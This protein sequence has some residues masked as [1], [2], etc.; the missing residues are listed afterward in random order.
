[1]RKLTCT[2]L[3]LALILFTFAQSDTTHLYLG[4]TTLKKNFTQTVTIKGK[5]LQQFPFTNLA[6][7]INVWL[8][9]AL[10]NGS[11]I[12]YV[13][14][15]NPLAD[16]NV[17]SVYDIE[18]ITLVQNAAAVYNTA[19]NKQLVLIKTKRSANKAGSLQAV[20][21]GYVV[22]RPDYSLATG[23]T[24]ASEKEIYHQYYL[25]YRKKI[26]SLSFGLSANYLHDVAP[27]S[28]G[29]EYV[30]SKPFQLNRF[31]LNGYA[32]QQLG[33]STLLSLSLN[34]TPQRTAAEL[35]IGPGAAGTPGNYEL[36]FGQKNNVLNGSVGLRSNLGK[37]WFNHFMATY[38]SYNL[39][40][41][42]S[43]SSLVSNEVQNNH[44][45]SSFKAKSWW[46]Q[47]RF[48]YI[49]KTG[50]WQFEPSVN[51]VYRH[52][53]DRFVAQ[54]VSI[55]NNNTINLAGY[56]A[57]QKGYLVYAVPSF[58]IEYKD[59]LSLQTG[60]L[61]SLKK[62]PDQFKIFTPYVTAT[63]DVVG[64]IKPGAKWSLRTFASYAIANEFGETYYA[65]NDLLYYNSFKN[66]EPRF[67]ASNFDGI[68]QL[69]LGASAQLFNERLQVSYNRYQSVFQE[70]LHLALP[71]GNPPIYNIVPAEARSVIDRVGINMQLINGADIKWTTG[72]NG[73]TRNTKLKLSANQPVSAAPEPKEW[74]GG[75]VNRLQ[76][77]RFNLQL[78]LAYLT[79]RKWFNPFVT[80]QRVEKGNS[81]SLQNIH[82]GYRI[83]QLEVYAGARNLFESKKI[84]FVDGRRYYGGGASINF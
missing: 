4:T 5:D 37:G 56:N 43:Q 51:V 49:A 57:S 61:Q 25:G 42:N 16:A 22:S 54:E 7:A 44:F 14:D 75:W 45:D 10:S 31:R 27:R 72:L 47:N 70:Q 3:C 60:L 58:G 69:Q 55:R 35:E 38:S 24:T 23:N 78:D 82:V 67:V 84:P 33:A 11:S 26:N 18:E 59:L 2:F 64:L 48:G 32:D 20:A 62:Q 40:T 80:P 13:V 12:Q 81:F 74:T 71:G 9:G 53:D 76:Y 41:N 79:N 63:A 1:M 30:K 15:G 36:L 19:G 17:L 68:K 77:G 50:H 83:N 34:Y 8:N 65:P 66:G 52:V 6:E 46:L 21:Q 29:F 39:N 73:S 28:K